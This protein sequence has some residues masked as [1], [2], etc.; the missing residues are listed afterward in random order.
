MRLKHPGPPPHTI[1]V[2]LHNPLKTAP[3]HGI[4]VDVAHMRSMTL[5]SL[6]NWSEAVRSRRRK[7]LVTNRVIR[8]R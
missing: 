6:W 5:E 3:L 7:C 4:L 8:R 2:P 1:T